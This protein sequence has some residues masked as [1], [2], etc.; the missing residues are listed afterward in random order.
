[1]ISDVTCPACT[2]QLS[3]FGQAAVLGHE[4]QYSICKQCGLVRTEEP[5]WLDEAY[6][7]A[8]SSLDVGLVGRC[9]ALADWTEAIARSYR[10]DGRLLDW[11]GGHGLLTRMLRDRGLDCWHHDSMAKNIHAVG[12]EGSLSD[13]YDLITAFEVLEHLWDPLQ[14]LKDLAARTEVLLFTTTLLPE[15]PRVPGS[16]WYYAPE[17]GQHVCFHTEASL[18]WIANTL[19]RELL[20]NGVDRHALVSPGNLGLIGRRIVRSRR[21]HRVVGPILRRTGATASLTESDAATLRASVRRS[22]EG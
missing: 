20:T 12:F 5:H 16:W 18:T 8:I 6:D 2:G 13:D 17:T 15:P 10:P 19:G 11:A 4:V 21:F 3:P 14:T 7:E 9:W 22:S 1:M